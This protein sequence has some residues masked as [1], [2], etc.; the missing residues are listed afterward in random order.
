LAFCDEKWKAARFDPL[1]GKISKS[2]GIIKNSI[3]IPIPNHH[4]KDLEGCQERGP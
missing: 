4:R 3:D 2:S 1:S